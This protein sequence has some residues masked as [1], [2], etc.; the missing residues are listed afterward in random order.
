MCVWGECIGHGV[1]ANAYVYLIS[2]WVWGTEDSR[3]HKMG[4][5]A[6]LE[7]EKSNKG[8]EGKPVTRHLRNEPQTGRGQREWRGLDIASVGL[9]EE[10]EEE[11]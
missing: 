4:K 11:E 7:S 3:V 9:P 6:A 1:R 2:S 8:T 10:E 5:M